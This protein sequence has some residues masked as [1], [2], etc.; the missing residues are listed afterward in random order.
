MA[1]KFYRM[2]MIISIMTIMTVKITYKML[3]KQI[4]SIWAQQ[5]K[6]T[7]IRCNNTGMH[8]L[9]ISNI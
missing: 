5:T 2:M 8:R 7:V 3:S 1:N 6:K 9:N 4:L